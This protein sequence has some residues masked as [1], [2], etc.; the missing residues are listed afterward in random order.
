MSL[1]IVLCIYLH[2]CEKVIK[3][4][5]FANKLRKRL[6]SFTLKMKCSF[7]K[8]I[9]PVFPVNVVLFCKNDFE[10]KVLLNK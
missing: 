6:Y 5:C 1:Y 4:F 3:C 7:P 2:F 10:E 9:F 8:S